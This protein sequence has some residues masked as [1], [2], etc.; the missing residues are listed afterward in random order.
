MS[1]SRKNKCAGLPI[2]SVLCDTLWASTPKLFVEKLAP[3]S[4]LLF[5][6]RRSS[7]IH[8]NLCL[9][10]IFFLLTSNNATISLSIEE[11][12]TTS[13]ALYMPAE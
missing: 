5:L 7:S 6:K 12:L 2:A 13:P 9:W 4:V 11:D 1:G 10:T 3:S 8:R